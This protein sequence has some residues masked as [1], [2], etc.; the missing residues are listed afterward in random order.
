MAC[1]GVNSRIRQETRGFQTDVRWA[2]ISTSGW[3]R[4]RFS[5]LLRFPLSRP[6]AAGYGRHA[7]GVDAESSTFIVECS[8]DTWAGLGFDTMPLG[9]C[10]SVLEKIFERQLDGHQLIGQASGGADAQWLNFRTVTNNTGTMARPSWPEM[11]LIPPTSPSDQGRSWRSRTLSRSPETCSV[12]AGWSRLCRHTKR[13]ARPQSCI[14]IAA[15]YSAQWFENVPRY[16]ARKPR[17]FA[18]LM[19]RR[20]SPLLPHLPPRLYYWLYPTS[21]GVPLRTAFADGQ[22]RRSSGSTAGMH[23]PDNGPV[24][25]YGEDGQ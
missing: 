9:D 14:S 4:I 2:G 25:S 22:H 17:Q 5:S 12:T 15:R 6:I 7:Y 24:I 18:T 23:K 1:D 19:Q 20:R 10:L 21:H 13:N 3:A 11:P 16:I 8:A